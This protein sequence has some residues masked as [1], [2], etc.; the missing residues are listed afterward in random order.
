MRKIIISAILILMASQMLRAQAKQ[1][2]LMVMPADIYCNRLGYTY[3]FDNQGRAETVS[4]Y[5]NLFKNDEN[6]RQVISKI[7]EM[8][9]DR[10][11][12]KLALLESTLKGLKQRG[13]EENAL[14]S[15]GSDAGLKQ[16]PV[17]II[18]SVAKADIIIDVDFSIKKMGPKKY[19]HFN[20]QAYDAYS[21]QPVGNASGDGAPG[22]SITPGALIEEAV[23]SHID[24]FLDQLQKHFDEMF[25][26]GRKCVF[27]IKVWQD[28]DDDLESE[29]TVDGEELELGEIIDD[30]FAKNSVKGRYDNIDGSE[31][32]MKIEARIPLYD[33]KN[34]PQDAKR[35]IRKL[36]KYL[37]GAPFNLRMKTY[38]RGLG[39]AW[40]IIGGK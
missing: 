17:D 28:A 34:R 5:E 31:N 1:P 22:F 8:I 25:I 18:K 15:K 38:N 29:Y 37:K 11:Y 6:S 10:G 36:R 2:K 40:L 23:L 26:Q 9:L 27:E 13:A 7:N 21:N 4:D 24:N 35:Y 30:W 33:E 20:L 19:I 39:E 32:F 3:E 14:R 12:T 16:S